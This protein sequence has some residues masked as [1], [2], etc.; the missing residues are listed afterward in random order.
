MRIALAG[1]LGLFLMV[2]VISLTGCDGGGAPPTGTQV[3]DAPPPPPDAI[4]SDSARKAEP[5][6]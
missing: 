4:T 3:Q 5:K 1:V 2:G 6:K